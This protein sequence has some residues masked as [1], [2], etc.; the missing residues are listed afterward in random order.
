MMVH[1][2]V[3]KN[4]YRKKCLD[5]NFCNV[6]C[7]MAKTQK[8]YFFY[9]NRIISIQIGTKRTETYTRVASNIHKD[10]ITPHTGLAN[11]FDLWY[12][13]GPSVSTASFWCVLKFFPHSISIALMINKCFC[14]MLYIFTLVYFD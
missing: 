14:F 2:I 1:S 13:I 12:F 5:I 4:N 9:G 3:K 11:R 10:L 6:D 8:S 7:N